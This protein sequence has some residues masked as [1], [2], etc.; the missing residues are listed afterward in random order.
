M[1]RN[2]Y[3]LIVA[4]AIVAGCKSNRKTPSEEGQLQWNRARA[5]VLVSLANDQYVTGNHDKC[6][7]TLKQ[8]LRMDPTNP[9]LHVLR[10]KLAIEQAELELAQSELETARKLDPKNAEVDYLSGVI[11]Q[12]WQRPEMSLQ[13]YTSACEKAPNEL[14]YLMARAETLVAVGQQD[15]ALR[16]LQ[17]KVIYF[18][19]SGVIRDA[20]GQLLARAG[21][22]DEAVEQLRQAAILSSDDHSIREHLALALLQ[23]GQHREAADTISRLVKVEAYAKRADL[24]AALGECQMKLAKFRDARSSFETAAQIDGSTPG[25]WLSFGKAALQCGDLPRAELATRKALALD[26]RSSEGNLMLG[27]VR[28]KQGRHDEALA[29]FQKAFAADPKDTTALCMMGVV[30]EKSGQH[31]AAMKCYAKALVIN[32]GDAM[33]SQ[34]MSAVE[35]D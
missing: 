35:V 33:A 8:A 17:E 9:G 22:Y 1:R 16:I 6:K 11:Y 5:S 29:G 24:Y 26:P 2:L 15:L 4:V 7:E 21:R 31:E 30:L 12:R 34:L 3:I 28:L 25:V 32:P 18:E 14:H 23:A 19:H 10:A 20:V 27:Y 13:F